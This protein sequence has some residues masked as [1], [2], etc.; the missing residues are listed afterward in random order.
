MEN[1]YFRDNKY[2][3]YFIME[4]MLVEQGQNKNVND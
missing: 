2:N 3:K 4:F 1:Y